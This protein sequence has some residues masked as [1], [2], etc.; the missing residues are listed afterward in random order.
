M[1]EIAFPLFGAAQ[2]VVEPGFILETHSPLTI[3][4]MSSQSHLS[5]SQRHELALALHAK[6]FALERKSASN[7]EGMSQTEHAQ[8]SLQEDADDATQL[9]G[10]HEVEGIVLDIDSDEF[11]AVNSALQRIQGKNY[12]LCV[13]C[14]MA[15]PF[16][17]LSVEPQAQRCISCEILHEG[18]I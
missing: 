11:D 16:E 5:E 10:V 8:L 15:I 1:F 14:N 6:L 18:T 2:I 9:A 4:M 17:R 13:D 12:G 3:I 7:L